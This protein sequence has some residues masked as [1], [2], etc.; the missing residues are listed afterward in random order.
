MGGIL[1]DLMGIRSSFLVN[2]TFMVGAGLLIL[3]CLPEKWS[4]HPRTDLPSFLVNPT[5]MLHGAHIQYLCL[6]VFLVD[7]ASSFTLPV[8]ALYIC[9]GTD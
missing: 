9:A 6:I 1:S 2:G 7:L 8:A 3:F 5:G 4:D